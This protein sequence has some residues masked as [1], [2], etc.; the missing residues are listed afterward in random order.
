MLILHDISS[1]HPIDPSHRPKI[2]PEPLVMKIMMLR[3]AAPEIIPAVDAGRLDKLIGQEPP[4]GEQIRPQHH[5][6]QGD[7]QGIREQLLQRMAVLRGQGHGGGELVMGLVES[8][9]QRG[10]MQDP[11]G[12]IK[13]DLAEQPA[14]QKIPGEFEQCRERSR[15]LEGGGW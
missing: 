15:D 11:M 3:P 10:N 12:N 4:H 7:R 8:S 1:D 9:V 13:E 14:A 5:R 2:S 6:R